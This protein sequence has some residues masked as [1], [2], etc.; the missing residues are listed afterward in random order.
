MIHVKL[1][2]IRLT[3][4]GAWSD[5]WTPRVDYVDTLNFEGEVS[6]KECLDAA[7]E[8]YPYIPR[9]E[10]VLEGFPEKKEFEE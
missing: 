7:K 5:K 4:P 8:A 6:A 9:W 2:R 10:M 1:L 3:K